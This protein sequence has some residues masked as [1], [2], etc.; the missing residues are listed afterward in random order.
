M[1]QILYVLPV[2][3]FESVMLEMLY[4]GLNEIFDIRR[5]LKDG[6]LGFKNVNFTVLLLP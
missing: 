1:F 5:K 4:S 2:I 6:T 3:D